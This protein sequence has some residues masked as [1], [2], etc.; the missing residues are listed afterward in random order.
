MKPFCPRVNWPALLVAM[1]LLQASGLAGGAPLSPGDDLLRSAQMWTAKN[2]PDIARQLLEKMLAIDPD[3]PLGLAAMGEMWVREGKLDQATQVLQT[4]RSR[5]PTHKA[6]KELAELVRIHSVESEKLANMRLLA[7]AGRKAEA[8]ELAKELFPQGVVPNLG[9]LAL[10]Y[11]QIVGSSERAA[12][13]DSVRQLDRLY[14]ETKE[15][16]YRLA[17]IELQLVQGAR[18]ESLLEAVEVLATQPDVNPLVLHDLWRRILD[19]SGSQ[20]ANLPRIQRFLSRYPADS[21]M[22][23]RLAAMQQA[24]ERAQREA[25]DPANIA[26]KAALAALDQGQLQLA[27]E[28]LQK[29]LALRPNDAESLGNLGLVRLRQGQHAQALALFQQAYQ[30]SQQSRWRD[31]Q[32]TTRFWGLLR[33]ADVA[34]DAREFTIA[35]ELVQKAIAMQPDNPEALVALADVRKLQADWPAATALYQQA[36]KHQPDHASAL[37]GLANLLAQQGNA[38]QALAL[39]DKAAAT[40]PELAGKLAPARADILSAQADQHIQAKRLSAALQALEAAV[41]LVPDDPWLRHSLARLYLRLDLKRFA[42]GVMDE[43]IAR[44]PT[45]AA[46]RHARALIRSSVDDEAGAL[47]DI[48]RI[49][50]AER[51]DGMMAMTRRSVIQ[52]LIAQAQVPDLGGHASALLQS[53][54]QRAG[55]D[56]DLL[57]SVANAWNRLGQPARGLAV[58]DRLAQRSASLPPEV[59]LRHAQWMNRA[60]DDRALGAYLPTLLGQPDWN[61]AQ[62]TDLL[63]LYAEHQERQIEA[64]QTTGDL[65]GAKQLAQAPLPPSSDATQQARTRARLLMAAAEYADAVSQLRQVLQ[66][67]P[68]DA[69]VRLELGSALV[70]LGRQ[71]EARAQAQWLQDNLP[72]SNVPAQL[73]LLRLWQRVGGV[74][75]ARALSD[76][77]LQ[78]AEPR[79]LV[80]AKA[81]QQAP[82][83]S[84]SLLK[85]FPTDGDVLLSA[86]RLE[87]AQGNHEYALHLLTQAL[88]IQTLTEAL[89]PTPPPAATSADAG[90]ELPL[91]KL[92]LTPQLSAGVVESVLAPVLGAQAMPL[93]PT[94]RIQREMDEIEMRRQSWVETGQKMLNKSSTS[95]ISTLNGWERATVA[96]WP[97]GYGGKYFLHLDQVQLNAGGLPVARAGA[98][99]YGQ[100]A[101]WPE[102]DYPTNGAL[103]R[104]SAHNLGL[105]YEAD[106][107]RWD[108]GAVGIGFPVTNLVGGLRVSGDWGDLG[109]SAGLAR[110][111][112][113]GSLLSYAGA[114]D[115]ITGQVW[116]GVVATGAS[117]RV[118]G[119]V[120]PY[121]MSLSAS[122]DW[123]TGRHVQRN[124]RTQLRWAADRDVLRTP[125]SVV[126]AGLSV[127]LT[128]HARDLSEYTWGQGGYYSP[129]RL[130]SLSVPLEWSGRLGAWT[131]Q[132]RG[133]V[134]WSASSSGP[135]DQFPGYPQL[136]A[137]AGN[138]VYKG[139][140]STGVGVSLRAALEY[141]ATR[142]WALG[143]LL[144]LDRSADYSPT[145]LLFY[146]RYLLDPVRVPLEDRP[147]PVQAYSSF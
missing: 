28:Q 48:G 61:D 30:K 100:V 32:V 66:D 94:A 109:Y 21:A 98:I 106:R 12:G 65:P 41:Q 58:F 72:A 119:D 47:D 29:S 46:M 22:V 123:L 6:T 85:R 63:A 113:T 92:R 90:D 40:D 45:L 81:E 16:R 11:H 121:S 82:A 38:A 145:N 99:D 133:A 125:H 69:D 129:Q 146:A 27:E 33:Q 14:A 91:P 84:A 110:R 120:G 103:Q 62:Q 115:P 89:P 140:S 53:A 39:L 112:L 17:Q 86:A 126:N 83:L 2:R 25:R 114:H 71:T 116:G 87:R 78:Q 127:A 144:E 52:Q 95:G 13:A 8:A 97:Q 4:L 77:L 59:Q 34:V 128:R 132:S 147:R 79:A 43:G 70:N 19:R 138:P 20:A 96:W 141:Q 49:S 80:H 122:Q 118:S 23:E 73:S 131:W 9:G 57:Q 107:W 104:A 102:G 50:I 36:L 130:L 74:A 68:A 76:R 135:T 31:L 15:S 134:S 26:R 88:K 35:A 124:Q 37:R 64:R 60:R 5:H 10:E 7:R 117:A 108:V 56:V 93:T 75:Q 143:G 101:A 44:Q 55:D 54:E 24:I 67:S 1:G 42:L 136:Q 111:P 3:S 137:Q 18:P 142:N 139:S 105:G 51:T